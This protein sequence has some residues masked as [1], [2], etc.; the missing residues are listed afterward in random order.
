MG[1]EVRTNLRFKGNAWELKNPDR[2]PMLVKDIVDQQGS[3]EDKKF[4]FCLHIGTSAGENI[5]VKKPEFMANR[6]KTIK[7]ALQGLGEELGLE[8]TSSLDEQ[9]FEHFRSTR[10]ADLV[11]KVYEGDV[12]PGCAMDDLAQPIKCR[13]VTRM[14]HTCLLGH[15]DD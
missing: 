4:H 15:R 11:V 8:E 2:V 7:E 13:G 9:H 6:L 10:F 3:Y 14:S 12:Q 1:I 5:N